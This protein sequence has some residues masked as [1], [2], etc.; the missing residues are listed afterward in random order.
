MSS[1]LN[2][3]GFLQKPLA[4]L[5]LGAAA[6]FSCPAMSQQGKSA[7]PKAPFIDRANMDLSVKPGDNFYQYASGNWIKNNPVP[8]KETRWGSFNVLRDFNINAVKTILMESAANTNAPAG[9]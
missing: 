4:F 8:A 9:S 6:T 1:K 2:K 5:L 3:S 7:S